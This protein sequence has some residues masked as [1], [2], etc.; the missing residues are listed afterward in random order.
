MSRR[1]SHPGGG[2]S[3][4]AAHTC[5]NFPPLPCPA[6][7][8]RS[9]YSLHHEVSN[10]YSEVVLSAEAGKHRSRA[11]WGLPAPRRGGAV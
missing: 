4:G 6:P 1:C 7:T 10:Q 8:P 3:G 5:P 11:P 2:S 9:I